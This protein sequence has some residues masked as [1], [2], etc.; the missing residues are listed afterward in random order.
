MRHIAAGWLWGKNIHEAKVFFPRKSLLA[1]CGW[2][3]KTQQVGYCCWFRKS[4]DS[5]LQGKYVLKMAN[6]LSLLKEQGNNHHWI[7]WLMPRVSSNYLSAARVEPQAAALST[8]Q[9]PLG[10][11]YTQHA[12]SRLFSPSCL[13][14]LCLQRSENKVLGNKRMDR[15]GRSRHVML[16][17]KGFSL[18]PASTSWQHGTSEVLLMW[19]PSCVPNRVTGL[20]IWSRFSDCLNQH[21]ANI[22]KEDK[23]PFTI[24]YSS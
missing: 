4:A 15:L 6:K 8:V 14:Y 3:K 7:L 23:M 9:T 19:W 22:V 24:S 18:L 16:L 12:T 17:S 20:K 21:R 10:T 1:K 5:I 2:E 13:Y 11:R